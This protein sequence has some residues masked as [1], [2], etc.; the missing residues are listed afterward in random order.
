MDVA[1]QIVVMRDGHVE[2][3]GGPTDLYEHPKTE[4]VMASSAR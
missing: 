2:Q 1:E 3:A 4:F